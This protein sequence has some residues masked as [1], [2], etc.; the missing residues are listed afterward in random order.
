MSCW[1]GGAGGANS[2]GSKL[3]GPLGGCRVRRQP[4]ERP[5][6]GPQ[7]T[8]RAAVGQSVDPDAVADNHQVGGY[9]RAFVCLDLDA[10]LILVERQ[11][12]QV[13]HPLTC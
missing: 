2:C 5:Q 13:A 4:G 11:S 10:L 3:Q 8:E 6:L 9:L 12:L 1:D 7:L